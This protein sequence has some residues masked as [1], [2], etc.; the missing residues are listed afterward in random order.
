M[1]LM[2]FILLGRKRGWPQSRL[3]PGYPA[4]KAATPIAIPMP[5]PMRMPRN[6]PIMPIVTACTCCGSLSLSSFFCMS[7]THRRSSSITG[8]S[9]QFRAKYGSSPRA[10]SASRMKPAWVVTDTTGSQTRSIRLAKK[11]SARWNLCANVSLRSGPHQVSPSETR[12]SGG[13]CISSALYSAVRMG[14]EML[15]GVTLKLATPRNWTASP[16]VNGQGEPPIR[17]D[18]LL[19]ASQGYNPTVSLQNSLTAKRPTGRPL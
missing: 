16:S 2:T 8:I 18:T 17:P 1:S 19:R 6:R 3:T 11:S 13:P 10:C 14:K 7:R 12:P 9:S 4:R 15:T 5:T